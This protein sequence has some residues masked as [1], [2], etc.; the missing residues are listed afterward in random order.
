MKLTLVGSSLILLLAAVAI[1]VAVSDTSSEDVSAQGQPV[2]SDPEAYRE[3]ER[4]LMSMPVAF[5]FNASL[6][7]ALEQIVSLTGFS[8]EVRDVEPR[9]VS[10]MLV[11]MEPL[12]MSLLDALQVIAAQHALSVRITPDGVIL[13]GKPEKYPLPPSS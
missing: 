12:E 9:E 3:M 6:D 11:N 13:T 2:V 1:Y 7:H 5:G 4:R 10:Q 8:I